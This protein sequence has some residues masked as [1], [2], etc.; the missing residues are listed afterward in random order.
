MI[1]VLTVHSY[2]CAQ[3]LKHYMR[4]VVRVRPLFEN[5]KFELD[6]IL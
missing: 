2:Q 3:G 1:P 6:V 4:G 5:E